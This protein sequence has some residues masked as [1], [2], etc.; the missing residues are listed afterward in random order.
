MDGIILRSVLCAVSY[1]DLWP[2]IF[3]ILSD[4]AANDFQLFESASHLR[5]RH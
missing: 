1:S 3:H 5:Q 4:E 2:M